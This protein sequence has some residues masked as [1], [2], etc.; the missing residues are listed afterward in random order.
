AIDDTHLEPTT[1]VTALMYATPNMLAR[2]SIVPVNTVNPGWM[3]AP[4]ENIS[5]YALETAMDELAC[6][7]E[8]DPIDLRLRN[9]AAVGPKANI[10]WTTRRLREG[11]VAGANAFG[12]A[13][14]NPKPRSM[15]E[16]RE[17]I[18]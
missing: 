15:R 18:G 11:Y 2:H 7:L 16:G 12:W 17:L 13:R 8:I 5:T 4:G 6:E 10:P 3:R 14:R 1:S 9:W